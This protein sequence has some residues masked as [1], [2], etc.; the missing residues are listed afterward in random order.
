MIAHRLSTVKNV[1]CIYVLAGGKLAEQGGAQILAE[2][3][4]VF[5]NFLRLLYSHS[6][7]MEMIYMKE[8]K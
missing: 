1:D 7:D 5:A 4:G 2:Q 8:K 6:K 3:N